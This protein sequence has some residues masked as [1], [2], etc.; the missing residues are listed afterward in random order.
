LFELFAAFWRY[1]RREGLA[2]SLR[3]TAGF[4]LKTLKKVGSP[5]RKKY[6]SGT[7]FAGQNVTGPTYLK[8]D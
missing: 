3:K 1:T 5:S 4:L 6:K 7:F 8:D 2:Y